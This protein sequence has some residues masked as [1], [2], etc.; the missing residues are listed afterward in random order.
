MSTSFTI[1]T[2]Q[3]AAFRFTRLRATLSRNLENAFPY[4]MTHLGREA[5]EMRITMGMARA[6]ALGLE[7]P[8]QIIDYLCYEMCGGTQLTYRR[9]IRQQEMRENP[10]RVKLALDILLVEN[11]DCSTKEC[12]DGNEAIDVEV[13]KL[14]NSVIRIRR[15][16]PMNH[17]RNAEA[18]Q[19]PYAEAEAKVGDHEVDPMQYLIDRE[20]RRGNRRGSIIETLGMSSIRIDV[21]RDPDLRKFVYQRFLEL[22]AGREPREEKK[23]EDESINKMHLI[24]EN[25]R[26]I[27]EKAFVNER[28]YHA[29]MTD[30][31]RAG[32]CSEFASLTAVLMMEQIPVETPARIYIYLAKHGNDHEITIASPT[33]LS[34]SVWDQSCEGY[35]PRVTVDAMDDDLSVVL[36]GWYNYKIETLGQYCVDGSVAMGVVPKEEIVILKRFD[37]VGEQLLPKGE[38]LR[39][40]EEIMAP[41][42]TRLLEKH[43]A[44]RRE[45]LAGLNEAVR[46]KTI[47]TEPPKALSGAYPFE[48]RNSVDDRRLHE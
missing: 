6:K 46:D 45:L 48:R 38:T 25:L 32:N 30:L 9:T 5:F 29:M 28:I 18:Q 27:L 13:S 43:K 14:R 10:V 4:H 1:R 34:A 2:A 20:I 12:F 37:P 3:I 19:C 21:I 11:E 39:L 22:G 40:F 36:D 8:Q 44:S 42:V 41:E 16:V 17:L 15:A 24:R 23:H 35:N 7:E 47:E 26:R 33:R 31:L